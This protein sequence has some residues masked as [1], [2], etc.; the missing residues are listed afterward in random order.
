MSSINLEEILNKVIGI[1]TK[2]DSFKL[3]IL[4][5]MRDAC[6]QTIDLCSVNAICGYDNY[7]SFIAGNETYIVFKD[8]ILNTKKQIV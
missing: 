6:N 1:E 7:D 3:A 8:S 5:A 2:S 4:E